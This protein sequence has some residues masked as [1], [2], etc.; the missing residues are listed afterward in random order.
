MGFPVGSPFQREGL[1]SLEKKVLGTKWQ[2]SFYKCHMKPKIYGPCPGE[3]ADASAR[4][5]EIRPPVETYMPAYGV[6]AGA[7][8][9]PQDPVSLGTCSRLF[10][11][12]RIPY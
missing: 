7:N 2:P 11:W 12:G 1:F 3:V 4:V 8:S 9:S 6:Q 5:T 10:L